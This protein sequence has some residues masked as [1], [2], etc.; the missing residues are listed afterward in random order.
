MSFSEFLCKWK[1]NKIKNI[2]RM[3]ITEEIRTC[4]SQSLH[5]LSPKQSLVD[6]KTNLKFADDKILILEAVGDL[7]DNLEENARG[8]CPYVHILKQNKMKY[9]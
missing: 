2:D 9:K 6:R 4:D 7:G 5:R 8:K 1:G 3:E